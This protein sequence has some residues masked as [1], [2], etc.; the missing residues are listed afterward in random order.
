MVCSPFDCTSR[1][2]SERYCET[3]SRI[4]GLSVYHQ[5]SP[6]PCVCGVTFYF[7][8]TEVIAAWGCRAT[9]LVCTEM[10]E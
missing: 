8:G 6:T 2:T 4:V 3:G 5:V 9:F 7:A 10:D 1:I